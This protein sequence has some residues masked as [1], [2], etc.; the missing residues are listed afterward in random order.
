MEPTAESPSVWR[1]AVEA[2]PAGQT[3]K[4]RLIRR[5]QPFEGF[6]V[7]VDGRYHAYVN[8]CPHAGTPLD[9]WPNEFLSEDGQRFVCSTHG[10]VFE[11]HTGLCV[12]GPCPGARLES[13]PVEADAVSVVVRCPS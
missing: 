8:R 13:L 11:T 5:G 10:A 6:I 1:C 4:F 2:I 12:E 7:N 9:T 3:A